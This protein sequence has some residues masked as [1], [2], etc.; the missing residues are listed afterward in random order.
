MI[1][2]IRSITTVYK[3]F[4]KFDLRSHYYHICRSHSMPHIILCLI[5]TIKIVFPYPVGS[6]TVLRAVVAD[7][8]S[9][10][11]FL[12]RVKTDAGDLECKFVLEV[13]FSDSYNV[14][15]RNGNMW[16]KRNF[17]SLLL[18][19]LWIYRKIRKC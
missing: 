8:T 7:Q 13:G 4:A 14:L 1:N 2:R 19:F 3:N 9:F 11:I 6:S 18:S 12:S 15:L 10:R 5:I 17:N 16:F